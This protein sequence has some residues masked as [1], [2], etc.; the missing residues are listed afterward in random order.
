MKIMRIFFPLTIL[1][2]CMIILEGAD[3]VQGQIPNSNPYVQ[4]L[5][6]A[7]N[8]LNSSNYVRPQLPAQQNYVYRPQP[9]LQQPTTSPY[10]GLLRRGSTMGLN[11]Y[12]IVR[13]EIQV[14]DALTRQQ[15]E[16]NRL[17]QDT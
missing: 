1:L 14:R 4:P 15:A 13:P 10:L 5:P 16:Q 6:Q 9:N 8:G 12:S 2:S 7:G 11:Y 17:A 3:H